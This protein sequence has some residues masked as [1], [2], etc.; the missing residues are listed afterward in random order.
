MVV[1][2]ANLEAKPGEAEAMRE[3]LTRARDVISKSPGYIDSTFLQSVEK[4]ERFILYIR[5]ENLEAHTEGFRKGPL[6]SEWRSHWAQH[7]AGTP[8][9]LHYQAFAG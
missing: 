3:G 6:F 1:E 2:I 4:P 8:D 7:Q 9:V 5:W